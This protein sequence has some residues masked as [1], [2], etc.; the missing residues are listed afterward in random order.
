MIAKSAA[1][2]GAGVSGRAAAELLR[3]EGIAVKVLDGNDVW[4]DGA[5]LDIAVT[6]PGVP[7]N[8]PWQLAARARGVRVI[9]ELQLG[10]ERWRAAGGRMLAVTGSKGKSSVVKFVSDTMNLAGVPAVPC[11]NYGKP[12]CEICLSRLPCAAADLPWAVVEVSSF[13][14]E[15][16]DLPSDTFAAAALLNL[17]DDH[18]DRHGTREVYHGLKR[19]MLAFA[20]RAYDFSAISADDV[21]VEDRA[22]FTGGYFDNPVLLP[23]GAAALS[24]LRAAGISAAAAAAGAAAFVPLPHRMQTVCVRDGVRFIDDSK[25]TSIAAMCAGVNMVAALRPFEGCEG[26]SG[27]RLIAGGLAKGDNPKN[28]ISLLQS[29]VKKVY[30]IG[31][32]AEQFSEAWSRTV[33]CEMCG[34]LDRAVAAAMRDA[35]RGEAVLLSPGAAS[36]DQFKSYTERGDAFAALAKKGTEK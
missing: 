8:H 32:C 35:V 31:C 27:C 36:F 26:C 18:L 2:F 34:T 1:V 19:R 5:V 9:S 10:A 22:L 30:L 15:T 12:L 16:T 24:L 14:M 13:Q 29:R 7:L 21:S 28:A 11:G 25:A 20:S 3:R 6:S 17:Q 23:N 33:P 4:P